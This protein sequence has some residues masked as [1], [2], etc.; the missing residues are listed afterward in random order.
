MKKKLF[1]KKSSSTIPFDRL[2][3][4]SD[5]EALLAAIDSDSINDDVEGQIG[6]IDL[7]LTDNYAPDDTI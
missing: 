3:Y 7:D 1:P 4:L 6:S 5:L 2:A